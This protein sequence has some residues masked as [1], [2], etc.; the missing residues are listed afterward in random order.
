PQ[1]LCAAAAPGQASC[2]AI[3]LVTKQVSSAAAK[4]LREDGLARPSAVSS[5]ASGPAGGYSPG[6]LAAAYGVNSAA[7]TSQTVAIVDAFHDPSVTADLNAF[8]AQYGLPTETSSSFKVVSQTGGSVSG[9]TTDVGWAGEIT[10]DVE[11]VR[12]LCHACKILL[13]EANS[14][15]NDDL[16]AAVDEAVS[17]GA[18]IVSNS[19]GGTEFPADPQAAHYDHAGVAILASTGDDGWYDWDGF[20]LGFSSDDA[21][22]IPAS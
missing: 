6:Q 19:Y 8:D 11:A 7:A 17:L 4:Q 14:N 18:T 21:P 13:V 12:G 3:R 16:A 9:I 5:V 2:L 15:N 22:Q 1:R 20:N 10:L